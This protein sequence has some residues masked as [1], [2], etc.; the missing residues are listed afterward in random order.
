GRLRITAKTLA[1]HTAEPVALLEELDACAEEAGIEWATFLYLLYDPHTGRARIA[2]AGHPPPLVRHRDGTVHAVGDVLGV[3]LGVG[4]VPYRSVEIEIPE[5]ATVAL[6]TDG[7][8][9]AR[10]QD[11]DTG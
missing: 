9:E 10:G 6:Y 1:R 4:G 5:G 3:P 2:N 8:V 7:L 11:I